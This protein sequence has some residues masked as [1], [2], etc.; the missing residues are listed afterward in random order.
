MAQKLEPVTEEPDEEWWEHS[1]GLS[2]LLKAHKELQPRE[3]WDIDGV[4]PEEAETGLTKLLRQARQ[5]QAAQQ[6]RGA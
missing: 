1:H 5:H 4:Q 2:S 6:Q 3:P